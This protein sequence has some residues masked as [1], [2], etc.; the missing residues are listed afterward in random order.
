MLLDKLILKSL[1]LI[2]SYFEQK[3]QLYL[4]I[5]EEELDLTLMKVYSVLEKIDISLTDRDIEMIRC[6]LTT[7]AYDRIR[8]N[9]LETV[10]FSRE[11]LASLK[12][13]V[14]K[15]SKANELLKSFYSI[16]D[17]PEKVI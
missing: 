13:M 14:V 2:C 9:S 8:I 15:S 4:Y 16:L 17:E 6:W 11:K 10:I 12:D 7:I 3:K 1:K 5:D